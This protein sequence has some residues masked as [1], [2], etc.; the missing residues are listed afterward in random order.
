V[1][2]LAD[3]TAPE[4]VGEGRFRTEATT[5]VGIVNGL[6][7]GG[8]LLQVGARALADTV[9]APHPVTVT[10]HYLRAV[11]PGPLEIRTEALKVSGRHRSGRATL[12]DADG[13]VVLAVTGTFTDLT[14]TTGLT[15]KLA[16]ET[17]LPDFDAGIPWPPPGGR[18]AGADVPPNIM[19]RFRHRL[20]PDSFSWTRGKPSGIPVMEAWAAPETGTWDPL[21]LLT[22]ADVYPPPLFNMGMDFAWVPTL[23][24]TIQLRGLPRDDE[25]VACRFSTTEL[26]GGYLEEDGTI[27]ARD[28]RL[29]AISRQL[30]LAPRLPG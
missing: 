10:G 28:G 29:L 23:E 18:P 20:M 14:E 5:D 30:A 7:H 4:P 16:G 12:H 22:L 25:W 17:V 2:T 1:P 13:E 19:D 27:R 6:I 21:D 9:G 11:R 26:T 3:L 24:L 15:R 8:F